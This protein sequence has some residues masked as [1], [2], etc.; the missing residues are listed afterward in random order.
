MTYLHHGDRDIE[1]IEGRQSK[2]GL[3]PPAIGSS[4]LFITSQKRLDVPNVHASVISIQS[5]SVG[6]PSQ[7]HNGR[8]FVT[9]ISGTGLSPQH[10]KPR[11]N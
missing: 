10:S 6:R 2:G 3:L 4:K 8:A 11:M 1:A 7:M 9:T 5:L